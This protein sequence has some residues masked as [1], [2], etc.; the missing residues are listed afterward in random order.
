MTMVQVICQFLAR[1]IYNHSRG[2]LVTFRA[3][4]FI[5]LVADQRVYLA[6]LSYGDTNS[7]LADEIEQ[8]PYPTQLRAISAV[9]NS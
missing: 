3:V 9:H 6:S 2:P 1:V 5:L 8:I 7:G 4:E